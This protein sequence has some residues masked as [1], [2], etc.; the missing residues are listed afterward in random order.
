MKT[1]NAWRAPGLRAITPFLLAML[2][3]LFVAA[4]QAASTNS[5]SEL[6]EKGIYSEETK[7][8]LDGAMQ[9]YKQVV[10]EAKAG[11]AVAAQAQYRLGVCQYKKRNF[12]EANAAFEKLIKDYPDQKELVAKARDY[13]ASA[14]A[15]LPP[16]WVDGEALQ[17]DIKFPTGFKIGT[18]IYSINSGELNGRRIWQPHAR[19]FAGVQSFSRVEVEAEALGWRVLERARFGEPGAQILLYA[20]DPAQTGKPVPPASERRGRGRPERLGR[21]LPG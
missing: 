7:G 15:L 11:Q 4:A 21:E 14:M 6:L 8:D 12:S 5:L 19:T 13:L 17:L 3:I 18:V 1:S 10:S 2:T 9:L 20:C 16:P